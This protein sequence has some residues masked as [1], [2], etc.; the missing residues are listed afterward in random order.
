MATYEELKIS[1]KVPDAEESKKALAAI[2]DNFND[3]VSGPHAEGMRGLS[4]Q[5]GDL[6]RTLKALTTSADSGDAFKAVASLTQTFGRAGPIGIAIAGVA[7]LVNATVQFAN[8]QARGLVMLADQARRIRIHPA[9]LQA[10]VEVA[11]RS[12][13][14][15]QKFFGI[16]QHLH[17]R[18]VEIGERKL[19]EARE[20]ILRDTKDPELRR[21]KMDFLN[22][23]IVA[24]QA[25][26][27]DLA[28]EGAR[29][30]I[31]FFAKRGFP[32]AG[33]IDAEGWIQELS[34]SVDL[35][36]IEDKF[37]QVSEED[38]QL[39]DKM[40]AASQA[41]I[42]L[43]A[44][45]AANFES[46]VRLI[47]VSLMESPVIGAI[48]KVAQA[49]LQAE[50]EIREEEMT[51]KAPSALPDW[52]KNLPLPGLPF[53]GLSA[54]E[55]SARAIQRMIE[56]LRRGQTQGGTAQHLLGGAIDKSTDETQELIAQ[57]RRL[58][59]LLSGEEKPIQRLPIH[60]QPMGGATGESSP[61]GLAPGVLQPGGGAAS[62]ARNDLSE[63][64]FN[65]L[66]K[67][68]SFAGH[69]QTIVN[70]ARA[71]SL[72]PSLMA[73]ILAFETGYGKLR[74]VTDFNNPA[75]LMAGGRGNKNFMKFGTIEEGIAKA[76]EVQSRLYK[77]GGETI[78]GM[79]AIYAPIGKGGQPVAND[80]YGTNKQWPS[81][82]ARLQ[83]QFQEYSGPEEGA[84]KGR[85]LD[86]S[87]NVAQRFTGDDPWDPKPRADPYERWGPEHGEIITGDELVKRQ[88]YTAFSRWAA[89][90]ARG[91]SQSIEDRRRIDLSGDPGGL[92]GTG[93]KYGPNVIDPK[94]DA[95]FK[96]TIDDIRINERTRRGVRSSLEA[97]LGGLDIP[98]D[99][100]GGTDM[101]GRES[102]KLSDGR[103]QLDAG[104]AHEHDVDA[105]GDLNV[106]VKA[107]AG[108]EVK[109]T[110]GGMFDGN[111]SL[112]RQM[113]LPRAM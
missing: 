43:T 60:N 27:L 6:E 44:G 67:G 19:P 105:S 38:K 15:E 68:G 63:S 75:G 62:E 106:N 103:K 59:A 47:G 104:L 24:P 83:S 89:G 22:Q 23:M 71:N 72:P 51:G 73:S 53:L 90:S 61:L 40:V 110:G 85:R 34:G 96:T 3:V 7:E 13:I 48:M 80:P 78:A 55:H 74:A 14:D 93:P 35:L 98:V 25:E 77:Q 88:K 33:R 16:V 56:I 69:Y 46:I 17:E 21:L 91:E 97:Q 42:N 112:Q 8:S 58:N 57:F 50:K 20:R 107:P 84:G 4:R 10:E 70:A 81:S 39:M 102:S 108:T 41:W 29:K 54:G 31:D 87:V 45:M 79:G 76:A 28:I 11:R 18:M 9:Q 100:P 66:M 92:E 94:A 113:E 82:V 109:A 1:V 2:K 49:G 5:V 101:W 32:T 26:Q 52:M 36:R 86:Q 30:I 99:L 65:R 64:D 12:L 37:A 95:D 111:V